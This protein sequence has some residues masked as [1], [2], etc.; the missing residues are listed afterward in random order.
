M[1]NRHL[2]D[3]GITPIIAY[4]IFIG[5][6]VFGSHQ[7]FERIGFALYIYPIIGLLNVFKL[8][9]KDRNDFLKLSFASISYKKIR[10]LENGF[11]IL[12][13]VLFLLYKQAFLMGL[14]LLVLAIILSLIQ[15][16]VT[17]NFTFPTP[18]KKYPF[19][20]TEGFRKTFYIFP[21]I[22]FLTYKSVEV[23]NFNL[24]AFSIL[25]FFISCISY[26][27]KTEP[28]YYVW[29]FNKSAIN[30][31]RYKI[32][33]A[34]IATSFLVLPIIVVLSVFYTNYIHFILMIYFVGCLYLALFI[35]AKYADF[36]KSMNFPIIIILFLS[37]SFPPNMLFTFPYLYKQAI[38]KLKTVLND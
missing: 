33:N 26:F 22:A 32:R 7:L 30:F 21:F 35:T 14:V 23:D 29:V 24:G 12:P 2:I 19:E 13:F 17:S 38:K 31:L 1:L 15:F 8:S 28:S 37:I 36:P 25:I 18:F 34:I 6:F 5:V 4:F 27:L 3:F 9:T 20:F 10:I 16:N 11:L